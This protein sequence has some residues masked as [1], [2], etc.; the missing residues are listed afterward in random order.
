MVKQTLLLW[1]DCETPS[2]AHGSEHLVSSWWRCFRRLRKLWVQD[3]LLAELLTGGGGGDGP[4]SVIAK[5]LASAPPLSHIPSLCFLSQLCFQ[6]CPAAHC[7][8]VPSTSF[9]FLWLIALCPLGPPLDG[10]AELS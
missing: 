5:L 1:F 4:W 2:Q 9:I 6:F 8:V 10:Q 7:S 3:A